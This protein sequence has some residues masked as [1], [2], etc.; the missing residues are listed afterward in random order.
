MSNRKRITTALAATAIALGSAACDQESITQIKEPGV[1]ALDSTFSNNTIRRFNQVERLANPLVMEAF[2][3]KREHD[4]YDN[5]PAVQD[6]AHFTDDI[7]TFIT[8]VAKRNNAY[9]AAIAGALIGTPTADPGDK[10]RVYTTRAAGVT[11]AT[12][13]TAANVG[14][15]TQVLDPTGGYGGRKLTG[16]DTVDKS[17]AAV[18][19]NVLGNNTNV[20]PGLVTD[21]VPANNKPALT[22]FPYLPEPN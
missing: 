10:I 5:L 7:V 19:G 8:T 22:T 6:P 14:Y 21:N 18:F 3:E 20:S 13:A 12:M 17:L 11:A 1:A 4:A 2:V 15:L 9:A 16:D